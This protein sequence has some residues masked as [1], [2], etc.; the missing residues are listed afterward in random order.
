M[1]KMNRI[2][3]SLL[4]KETQQAMSKANELKIK[5]EAGQVDKSGK[6]PEEQKS[7]GV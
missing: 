4:G 6:A 1:Q 7:R 5:I 3:L 2:I